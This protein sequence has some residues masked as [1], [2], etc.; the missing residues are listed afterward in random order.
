MSSEVDG[1]WLCVAQREESR[2]SIS[3]TCYLQEPRCL[4]VRER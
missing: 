2:A 1:K 4:V 3:D